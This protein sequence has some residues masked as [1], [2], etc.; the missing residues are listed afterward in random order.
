MQYKFFFIVK[1]TTT[2]VKKGW[3]YPS[4]AP[5]HTQEF[6][7]GLV[8]GVEIEPVRTDSEGQ[9]HFINRSSG[10]CVPIGLLPATC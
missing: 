7:S 2:T 1:G 8:G 6:W 4:P 10:S 5:T 9:L 3:M